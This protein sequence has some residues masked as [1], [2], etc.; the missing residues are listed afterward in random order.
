MTTTTQVSD[1]PV[2]E[3]TLKAL[4]LTV[5]Y[6]PL[7]GEP[8]GP[9]LPEGRRVRGVWEAIAVYA[10]RHGGPVMRPEVKPAI[11]AEPETGPLPPSWQRQLG[12]YRRMAGSVPVTPA[13]PVLPGDDPEPAQPVMPAGQEDGWDCSMTAVLPRVTEQGGTP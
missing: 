9:P 3:E 7:P 4:G 10:A 13:D 5:L 12:A 8:G 2:A 11:V 1:T 6:G